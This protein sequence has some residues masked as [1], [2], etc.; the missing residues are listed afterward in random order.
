MNKLVEHLALTCEARKSA[1]EKQQT[2]D[3]SRV[4]KSQQVYNKNLGAL[5]P[6]HLLP[7]IRL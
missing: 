7:K 6:G 4:G 1:L 5:T 3:L 2:G